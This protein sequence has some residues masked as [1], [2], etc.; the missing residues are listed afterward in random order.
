MRL[1]YADALRRQRPTALEKGTRRG[2]E[3]AGPLTPPGIGVPSKVDHRPGR[4]QPGANDTVKRVMDAAI[5]AFF[6]ALSRVAPDV[7]GNAMAIWEEETED[8]LAETAIY[9]AL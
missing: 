4:H 8:P 5:A 3:S 6:R 9:Q 2:P 1:R 7:L